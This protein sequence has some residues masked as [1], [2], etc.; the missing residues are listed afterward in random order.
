MSNITKTVF[1]LMASNLFMTYAWYGV[2][3]DFKNRHWFIAVLAGWS[4]AFIEYMILVPANRIGAQALNV[5]QLK[6][7][8]EVISLSVFIP[9]ALFYLREKWNWN[10]LW[11]GI[12]LLGAVYFMFV[13]R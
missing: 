11:A 12:C 9:F 3:H 2:L 10:F 7:L 8:Q 4:V 5:P 6:I 13:R 1:M